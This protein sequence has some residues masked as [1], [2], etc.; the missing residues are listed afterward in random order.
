MTS[1][2]KTLLLLGLLTGIIL[3][4]GGAIGGRVGLFIAFGFALVM[5]VGSYW[6]SDK[7]VLSMYRAKEVGPQDAPTLHSIVDDLARKA[8]LPKPRVYIVPQ[9][10]P[11]AFATG[12][13]PEHGVV[14]VTQGLLQIL[15][16]EELRGVLAHEM[17]HIRNRDI[18]V[19]TI[20]GVLAS[21]VMYLANIAQFTA[22]FGGFGGRDSEGGGNP[23]AALMLAMIA[24][25][26]AMLV[27]MAIS[28]SREY[29]ADDTGAK[30]AGN[31][32]YLANALEKLDAYGKQ[33]PMRLG[34]E[35]TSH[36]FIVHPFSGKKAMSLF[37]T[38]PPIQQ[39]VARLRKMAAA[40]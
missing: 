40:A 32:L 14:A 12:R 37:A 29:L 9:D 24:P 18:L 1:Q 6:Y 34:N 3:F 4:L 22:I 20:A 19:Q 16:T 23:I 35:A 8:N 2:I 39:R 33:V 21:V 17:G 28:R 13:D 25:I 30:L 38:H 5:N 15:S 36:M 27:Q 7:L 26:A 10:S 31:P 11:N